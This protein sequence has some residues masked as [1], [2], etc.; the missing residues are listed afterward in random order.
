MARTSQTSR[1]VPKTTVK[2]QPK[3]AGRPSATRDEI[4]GSSSMSSVKSVAKN[5]AR[6]NATPIRKFIF[7][8]QNQL[9]ILIFSQ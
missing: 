6:K 7:V 8:A 2:K 4:T 5:A 3:K 1:N 9:F